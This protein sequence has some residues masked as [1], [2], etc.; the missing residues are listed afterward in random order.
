MESIFD[1]LQSVVSATQAGGCGASDLVQT[2][3]NRWSPALLLLVRDPR[4][5]GAA[6]CCSP[7][8]D[9]TKSAADG[10]PLYRGGGPKWRPV[11][12]ETHRNFPD[13]GSQKSTTRSSS[14]SEK[15]PSPRFRRRSWPPKVGMVDA[16]DFYPVG[17]VSEREPRRR[18]DEMVR[19]LNWTERYYRTLVVSS[20]SRKVAS[21]S[22]SSSSRRHKLTDGCCSRS[23]PKK[24]CPRRKAKLSSAS[25][26]RMRWSEWR[27]KS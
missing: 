16:A 7:R 8:L 5:E 27:S 3:Q 18:C 11:P 4:P 15:V 12:Q 1:L 13:P 21:P 24:R 22:S 25:H 14:C 6:C 23:R 19:V 9:S 26:K 20:R 2:P 17:K 10:R